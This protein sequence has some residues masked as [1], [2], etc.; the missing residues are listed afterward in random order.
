[1]LE[2]TFLSTPYT[3]AV[4]RLR[5]KGWTDEQAKGI[6]QCLSLD[7][8]PLNICDWDQD[9]WGRL[10]DWCSVNMR[11]PTSLESQLDHLHYELCNNYERLGT[12]IGATTTV[13]EAR[14]A[15]SPYVNAKWLVEGKVRWWT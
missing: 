3:D 12:E 8:E 9:R 4:E 11:E 2:R 1:M 6:A 7:S 13:E 14:K 5:V 10:H 15:F